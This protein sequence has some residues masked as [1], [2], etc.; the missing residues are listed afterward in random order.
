MPK[1]TSTNSK[2]TAKDTVDFPSMEDIEKIL[3]ETSRRLAGKTK[4]QM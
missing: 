2:G 4:P 1:N 3:K